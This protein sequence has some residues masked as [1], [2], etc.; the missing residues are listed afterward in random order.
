MCEI[1][2]AGALSNLIPTKETRIVY[3]DCDVLYDGTNNQYTLLGCFS[4][5]DDVENTFLF[6]S[7]IPEN[8]EEHKKYQQSVNL[9]TVLN[10]KYDEKSN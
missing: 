9:L 8:V 2:D 4:K 5:K 1:T 10:L 3:L 7:I 6:A